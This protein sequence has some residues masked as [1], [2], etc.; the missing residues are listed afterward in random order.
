MQATPC[1]D[2]QILENMQKKASEKSSLHLWESCCP[3]GLGNLRRLLQ[4]DQQQIEGQ[5]SKLHD[6]TWTALH[7]GK[8]SYPWSRAHGYPE[9]P[10]KSPLPPTIHGIFRIKATHCMNSE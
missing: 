4:N 7:S 1:S 9:P 10:R 3:L 6:K 8:G 5:E 2:F